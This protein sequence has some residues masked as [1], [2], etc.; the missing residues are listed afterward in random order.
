MVVV[1]LLLIGWGAWKYVG[2]N[3]IAHHRQKAALVQLYAQWD[4][5]VDPS[6]PGDAV[7]L[8][9]VRRF[10]DEY[11]MPII[12]GTDHHSL[13]EGVG[14]FPRSQAPGELGNFAL[15][16]HRSTNGEPFR[17]FPELRVGDEVIIET[18]TRQYTYTLDDNGTDHKVDRTEPW[19]VGPV[20]GHPGAIPK[21][22][23]LTLV[24][25]AEFLPT[26]DRS[27]V[28]GHLT[29]DTP[30]VPRVARLAPASEETGAARLLP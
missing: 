12:M 24:T 1:G 16:A 13:T 10:G 26:D 25:C 4:R 18:R 23:L 17:R 7:A 21:T 11:V 20:P 14:W 15:A 2:T 6:R 29:G 28:F 19:I 5:G 9:R 3:I 27:Y 30:K 8:V 22:A